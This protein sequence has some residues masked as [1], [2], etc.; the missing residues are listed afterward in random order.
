MQLKMKNDHDWSCVFWKNRG[1][2]LC[3]DSLKK[4]VHID[5]KVETIYIVTAPK[6]PARIK[7]HAFKLY[8]DAEAVHVGGG[9]Y[10]QY[11]LASWLREQCKK[12]DCY[13]WIEY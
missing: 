2:S 9:Q 5:K 1:A 13:A 4:K 10:L 8:D 3:Y 11:G 6:V 7:E 12:G